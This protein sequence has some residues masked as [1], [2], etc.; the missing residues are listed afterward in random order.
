[1]E[2]RWL[3]FSSVKGG[4]GKTTAA[5][6]TAVAAAQQGRQVGVVDGDPSGGI[7]T[8]LG[9]PDQAVGLADVLTGRVRV[10]DALVVSPLGVAVL[11]GTRALYRVGIGHEAIQE[12]RGELAEIVELV[13]A[14]T[15]PGENLLPAMLRQCDRICVLFEM[16]R[17]SAI[18]CTDTLFK[19]DEVGALHSVGGLLPTKTIWR[20][21]YPQD[22]D[23]RELYRGME[24][25]KIA[26]DTRFPL[27]KQ[28]SRAMG[29]AEPPPQRLLEEVAVPLLHEVENRLADEARLRIWMSYYS[30]E[31]RRAELAAAQA[32]EVEA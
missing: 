16:D 20:A 9:V 11:A 3:G 31:A 29:L 24:M 1:M 25:L 28:W 8:A 18:T 13:V 27:S 2:T 5:W 32:V 19:A 23:G 26:Y 15:Q 7:S 21:G 6:A 22:T 17:A 12:V 14:D 10:R 30:R 4:A